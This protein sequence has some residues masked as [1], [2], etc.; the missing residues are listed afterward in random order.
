VEAL[1]SALDWLG[2]GAKT[3][4][5]YGRMKEVS[6]GLSRSDWVDKAIQ[7]IR[8]ETAVMRM[9]HYVAN[10]WPKRQALAD[11][12][13]KGAAMADIKQRWKR[14]VGGTTRLSGKAMKAAKQI[15]EADAP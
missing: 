5:G 11:L 7:E 4:V 3:A 14:K 2:A 13:V 9:R 10:N 15:Y 8:G 6:L 1:Q 12:T